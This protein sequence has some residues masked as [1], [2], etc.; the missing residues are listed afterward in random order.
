MDSAVSGSVNQQTEITKPRPPSSIDDSGI[1]V[2]DTTRSRQDADLDRCES[3]MDEMS[4]LDLLQETIRDAKELVRVEVELAKEEAKQ[5]LK[6]M[7]SAA[8]AFGVA[9]VLSLMALAMLLTAILLAIGPTPVVALI[10]TAVLLAGAVTV[11]LLGRA[12]IPRSA[13]GRTRARVERDVQE[14]RAHLP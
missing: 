7:K 14:L 4:T 11:A 3:A 5:Q 6:D 9:A 12:K 13:L 8:I 2:R 10:M 1:V